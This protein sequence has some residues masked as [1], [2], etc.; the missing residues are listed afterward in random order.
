NPSTP[1]A[2]FPT[3]LGKARR[4]SHQIPQELN[5]CH[6]SY[7][8]D[9]TSPARKQFGDHNCFLISPFVFLNALPSLSLWSTHPPLSSALPSAFATRC[10]VLPTFMRSTICWHDGKFWK[11]EVMTSPMSES[12]CF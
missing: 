6:I 2:R 4:K 5:S 10:L 9:P 1:A 12:T 8:P 7:L 3:N 11:R